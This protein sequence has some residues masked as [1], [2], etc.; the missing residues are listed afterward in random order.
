MLKDMSSQYNFSIELYMMLKSNTIQWKNKLSP[1]VKYLKAFCDYVLH[2]KV[3]AFIPHVS[4][5]DILGKHDCDRRRGKWIVKIQEFYLGIKPTKF[6]KGQ[7]LAKLM[8]EGNFR[9]IGINELNVAFL[10]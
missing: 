8:V 2:S 6:I 9:T 10:F 7:G 1:G 3:I 5:K 4:V